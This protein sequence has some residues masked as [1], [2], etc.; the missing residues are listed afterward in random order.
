MKSHKLDVVSLLFGIAFTAMGLVFLAFNNPWRVLLFDL[1]WT[2]LAPL[3]LIAIGVLVMAPLLR[4][5]ANVV[6]TETAEHP[7]PSP[8]ESEALEELPPAPLI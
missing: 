3:A 7:G 5:K 2:W 8:E 6:V 4:P 1:Q